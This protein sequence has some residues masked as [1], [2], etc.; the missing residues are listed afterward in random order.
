MDG[1][2]G[3]SHRLSTRDEVSE[4]TRNALL[5]RGRNAAKGGAINRL[6]TGYPQLVQEGAAQP[7]WERM[8]RQSISGLRISMI[9][10]RNRRFNGRRAIYPQA[11]NGM[12][13]T[14]FLDRI[15]AGRYNR[16][17]ICR[18]SAVLSGEGSERNEAHLSAQGSASQ[19]AARL[20]QP[21]VVA[22]WP[23]GDQ[24]ET[25][26]GQKASDSIRPHPRPFL[27]L[28]SGGA[29]CLGSGS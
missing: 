17:G 20:S 24:E 7:R 5:D 21:Y 22:G 18:M 4:K 1:S 19:E 29:R 12:Q 13:R 3:D 23:V 6:V 11:G 8:G 16:E 27:S 14:S 2:C 25:V 15:W 26:T 10:K 9:T 28:L